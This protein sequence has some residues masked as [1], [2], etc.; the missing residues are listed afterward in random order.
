MKIWISKDV[1]PPFGYIWVK[2]INE[3][4]ELIIEKNEPIEKIS[5]EYNYSL[6]TFKDKAASDFFDWLDDRN[7]DCEF[8]IH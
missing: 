2:T 7:Y 4:K 5:L 1:R 8:L 3:A 6:N